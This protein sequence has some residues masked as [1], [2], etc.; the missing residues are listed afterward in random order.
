MVY[1]PFREERK[2]VFIWAREILHNNLLSFA[3]NAFILRTNTA[4]RIEAQAY[5]RSAGVEIALMMFLGVRRRNGGRHCCRSGGRRG[6]GGAADVILDSRADVGG[7]DDKDIIYK[8]GFDLR[9]RRREVRSTGIISS[10][11]NGE[12]RSSQVRNDSLILSDD[13][14]AQW[15]PLSVVSGQDRRFVE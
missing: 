10:D 9:A 7:I 3:K 1:L 12:E 13:K 14:S 6:R 11:L 4:I 2:K 15:A 8:R 5:C